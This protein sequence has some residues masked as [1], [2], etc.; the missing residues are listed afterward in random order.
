MIKADRVTKR[1]GDIQ[2]LDNISLEIPGGAAF[3]LSGASGSG[4]TTLLR[5]IAGLEFPDS[6]TVSLLGKRVSAPETFIPPARRGVAIAFQRPALWPHLTIEQNV[7]FAISRRLDARQRTKELLAALGLEAAAKRKP[8]NL[9]GGEAQ[10]VALARALAPR[11]KVLLLDEPFSNLDSVSRE[12]AV[13]L[14]KKERASVGWTLLL[15]S[16]DSGQAA[17]IC[18]EAFIL[19]EGRAISAGERQP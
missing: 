5:L 15:V 14:L 17:E 4:K 10:R 8:L 6:G 18:D 12:R 19:H 3:S 13:A 9:S 11:A 2:V 7:A 1:Y 16:H